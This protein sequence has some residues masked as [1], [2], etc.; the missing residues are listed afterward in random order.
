MDYQKFEFKSATT[1]KPNS[2][3]GIDWNPDPAPKSTANPRGNES[4][5]NW[6]KRAWFLA[7]AD[8]RISWHPT[9]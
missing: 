8:S 3:K 7:I 5:A 6:Q 9:V 1:E 2:A 4:I